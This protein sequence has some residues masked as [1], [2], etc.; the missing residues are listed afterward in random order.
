MRFRW[1]R[2]S[3]RLLKLHRNERSPDPII[4][5]VPGPKPDFGSGNHTVREHTSPSGERCLSSVAVSRHGGQLPTE[6]RR[7]NFGAVENVPA[8]SGRSG[9][10]R[11]SVAAGRHFDRSPTAP[12]RTSGP[13][14]S[15]TRPSSSSPSWIDYRATW[16]SS[17]T[18]WKPVRTLWPRTIQTPTRPWCK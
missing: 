14:K 2:R 12:G 4:E 1:R 18:C 5:V 16:P 9:T 6:I 3:R 7:N 8:Q 11:G 13:A 10:L 15:I 17:P